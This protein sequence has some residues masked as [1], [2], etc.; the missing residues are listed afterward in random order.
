M[1]SYTIWFLARLCT[2]TCFVIQSLYCYILHCNICTKTTCIIIVKILW[3]CVQYTTQACLAISSK[4]LISNPNFQL[5]CKISLLIRY[6]WMIVFQAVH[7]NY[8]SW[9]I[10]G[11]RK[12]HPLSI[13]LNFGEESTS[14][15]VLFDKQSIHKG[16]QHTC[17]THLY[18]TWNSY[19]HTHTHTHTQN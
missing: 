8:A 16:P 9:G 5:K 11:S 12:P 7:Y 15:H 2:Y 14:P 17:F 1:T 6:S 13:S 10:K 19:T 18:S 4:L 3:Y